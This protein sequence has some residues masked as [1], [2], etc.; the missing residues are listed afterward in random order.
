L[1]L[2][3]IPPTAGFF[4]KYLLFKELITQ[5]HLTLA[6]IGVLA[7]LVSVGY[8]LRPIMAMYMEPA[9]EDAEPVIAPLAGATVLASGVLII[10]LGLLPSSLLNGLAKPSVQAIQATNDVGNIDK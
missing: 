6:I 10:V 7:S 2:A 1:S 8:Y 5:G 3:G 4:G 9:T